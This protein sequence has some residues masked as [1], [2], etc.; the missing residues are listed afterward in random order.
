MSDVTVQG[1]D[2]DNYQINFGNASNG[3]PQPS[4]DRRTTSSLS[5]FLPAVSVTMVRSPARPSRFRFP[6]IRR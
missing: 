1:T 5:G 6:T 4:V 2:A 3:Q